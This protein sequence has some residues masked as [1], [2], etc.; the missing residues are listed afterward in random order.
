MSYNLTSLIVE[1][2]NITY[3]FE[4]VRCLYHKDIQ[5]LCSIKVEE[6][7]TNPMYCIIHHKDKNHLVPNYK[8]Y[9]TKIQSK[10]TTL[11]QFASNLILDKNSNDFIK[12]KNDKIYKIKQGYITQSLLAHLNESTINGNFKMIGM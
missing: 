10:G 7:Q 3:K 2:I 9:C 4:N 8:T 5:E 6:N 11:L 1:K 12:V